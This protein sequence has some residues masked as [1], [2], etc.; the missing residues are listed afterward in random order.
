MITKKIKTIMSILAVTIMLWANGNNGLQSNADK[1][2]L[3]G[4]ISSITYR[5][6]LYK[7]E[8]NSNSGFPSSRLLENPTGQQTDICVDDFTIPQS[9]VWAIEEIKPYVFWKNQQPDSLEIRIYEDDGYGY[10]K[11]SPLY[12]F[13]TYAD[14]PQQ[15]R[16]YSPTLDV[17]SENIRLAKGTYWLG[18]LGLHETGVT[19]DTLI[20][21]WVRKD[22]LIGKEG[23]CADSIGYTYTQAP[24]DWLNIWAGGNENRYTSFRFWLMG[25][26]ATSKQNSV[27]KNASS[28]IIVSLNPANR[29]INFQLD[30]DFIQSIKL[31]DVAGRV[32][33][34][35]LVTLPSTRI[36]IV[37]LP[38]GIYIYQLYN[39]KGLIVEKGNFTILR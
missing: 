10:P 1:N 26:K 8:F 15:M 31:Y 37:T 24:T 38:Q 33:R 23:K 19:A 36:N 18:V 12:H 32:L 20:M 14:M 5:E 11:E 22:T 2:A 9:E 39:R 4:E 28:R 34:N 25:T 27:V 17:R 30:N 35:T 21:Y 7:N 16:V 13:N 6:I 29:S 3:A